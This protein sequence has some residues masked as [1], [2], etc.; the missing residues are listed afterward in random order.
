MAEIRDG[1]VDAFGVL[2]DRYYARAYG[3]AR[4]VCRDDGRAE[5]AVQETFVSIWRTRRTD[6]VHAGKVTAWVLTVARHRAIDVARRNGSHAAHR[7]GDESLQSVP[8]PG[9]VAEQVLSRIRARDVRRLL[10]GLPPAQ[11]EAIALAFYGGLTH[12]EIA[13]RLQIPL[14]TVKG[15]IRLGLAQ[16]RSDIGHVE[17]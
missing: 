1:S 6:D 4:S 8:A 14:G 13:A 17:L 3:V 12:S 16:L 2:Y 5:E 9:G 7:A 11:Y 15:R 10:E